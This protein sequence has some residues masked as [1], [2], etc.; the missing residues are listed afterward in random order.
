MARRELG[1]G[2]GAALQAFIWV[3]CCRLNS[4]Q[5]DRA[6]LRDERKAPALPGQ[7]LRAL[8][9]DVGVP[10]KKEK[11]L[12]LGGCGSTSLEVGAYQTG[13]RTHEKPRGNVYKGYG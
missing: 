10:R 4:T 11:L 8:P 12:R 2:R 3:L 13:V 7:C 9:E 1:N 6:T 5:L